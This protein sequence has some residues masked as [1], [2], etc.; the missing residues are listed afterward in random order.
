MNRNQR[1]LCAEQ[2]VAICEAGSYVHPSGRRVELADRIKRAVANSRLYSPEAM[3][4]SPTPAG[5][6][7]AVEVRN[8]TTF[9][10]LQR[11]ARSGDAPLCCLNFASARHPGGGFL[12]GAQAQ[13]ESLA[14]A[15][16]LYQCLL[17]V[18]DYYE[19]NRANRSA[20]YLDLAIFS[21]DVP[22]FRDDAGNLLE[23]P[24]FAS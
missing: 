11:L 3:A 12:T 5:H 22:F 24:V 14:R 1:V 15:S 6:R 4:G 19:R 2:T 20:L 7:A 18:P 8:E 23:E 9:A 21:P 13:E 10:A 16:A 17:A